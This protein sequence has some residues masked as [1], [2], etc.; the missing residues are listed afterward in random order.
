MMEDR[1]VPTQGAQALGLL[2][3]PLPPALPCLLAIHSSLYLLPCYCHPVPSSLRALHSNST[4]RPI[5]ACSVPHPGPCCGTFI[6][7]LY[8]SEALVTE[9]VGIKEPSCNSSQVLR[10]QHF[11]SHPIWGSGLLAAT[12][13]ISPSCPQESFSS[14]FINWN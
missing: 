12:G 2:A 13:H 4:L 9:V 5:L 8:N 7:F 14:C 10:Q 11:F 6:M 1:V 3:L